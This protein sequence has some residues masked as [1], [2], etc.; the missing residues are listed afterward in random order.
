[1]RNV[2]LLREDKG[3]T[4]FDAELVNYSFTVANYNAP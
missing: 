3:F 1:M 2:K 4:V